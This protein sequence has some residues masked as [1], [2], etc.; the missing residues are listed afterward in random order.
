MVVAC[1]LYTI[2]MVLFVTLHLKVKGINHFETQDFIK[3]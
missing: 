3:H 1:H 2:K